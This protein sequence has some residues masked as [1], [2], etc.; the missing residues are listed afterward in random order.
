MGYAEAVL[1]QMDIPLL[2]L[3][4]GRAANFLAKFVG[5]HPHRDLELR[6]TDL[7]QVQHAHTPTLA[8]DKPSKRVAH[9]HKLTFM[10][11]TKVVNA[12]HSA[13]PMCT[14]E[15]VMGPRTIAAK[16]DGGDDSRFH[17]AAQVYKGVIEA[18]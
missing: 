8:V 10:S 18:V 15:L 7:Q 4:I 13:I 5:D 1:K 12:K 16:A 3:P 9:V 6:D 2:K 11:M 14:Y 17:I